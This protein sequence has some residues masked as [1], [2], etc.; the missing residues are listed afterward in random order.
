MDRHAKAARVA[1]RGAAMPL[2]LHADRAVGRGGADLS[3]RR[4]GERLG[5]AGRKA[6]EGG[7]ELLAGYRGQDHLT[8]RRNCR[9]V[10][11]APADLL[12]TL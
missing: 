1:E 11:A 6:V 9:L 4:T 3:K 10:R 12:I 7:R 8:G 2:R 5:K